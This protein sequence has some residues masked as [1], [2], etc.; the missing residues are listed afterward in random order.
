MHSDFLNQKF[1]FSLS[2]ENVVNITV[3]DTLLD[4]YRLVRDNWTEDY[5][6]RERQ[7]SNVFSL[8]HSVEIN[9]LS[10]ILFFF[11]IFRAMRL[12]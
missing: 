12:I 4:L 9:L 11:N 2:S 7:V 6:N 5:Y 3:S 1:Y 10:G 8:I